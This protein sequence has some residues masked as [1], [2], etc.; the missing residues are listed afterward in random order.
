MNVF[1]LKCANF[2]Q[3]WEKARL[4]EPA[5]VA[6][7]EKAVLVMTNELTMAYIMSHH[8]Q[9]DKDHEVLEKEHECVLAEVCKSAEVVEPAAA[10]VVLDH[11]PVQQVVAAD[12]HAEAA[13]ES[14]EV[15]PELDI[16]GGIVEPPK[17]IM[18]YEWE[19]QQLLIPSITPEFLQAALVELKAQLQTQK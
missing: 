11:G 2:L 13:E 4:S 3:K 6:A 17:V 15:E 10:N 1:W 12:V 8:T 5:V 19:P 9:M 14:M 18:P 16:S 7:I